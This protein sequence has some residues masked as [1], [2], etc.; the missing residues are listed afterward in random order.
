MSAFSRYARVITKESRIYD[1]IRVTE[2]ELKGQPGLASAR[3]KVAES[4]LLAV[5]CSRPISRS[6]VEELALAC[7]KS[8]NHELRL[9]YQHISRLISVNQHTCGF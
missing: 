5:C 9:D 4:G 8:Q 6:I 2:V 1:P 3:P 7:R